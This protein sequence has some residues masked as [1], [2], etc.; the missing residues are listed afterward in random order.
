MLNLRIFLSSPGDV[1]R[2]RES[3]RKIINRV[4]ASL[5]RAVTLNPYFWEHEPMR[6]SEDFQSNIDDPGSFDIV[7]CVLWSRLG[8][9]LGTR[10]RRAD[11]SSY[12]SGTEYEF[13]QAI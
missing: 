10:H 1:G 5:G 4:E 3:C 12:S 6:P 13:E 9:R 2:E 11:G 8:T 7:I